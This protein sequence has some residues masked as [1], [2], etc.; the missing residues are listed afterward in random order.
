MSV[1]RP[2]GQ[3]YQYLGWSL[4]AVNKASG[5][6]ERALGTAKGDITSLTPDRILGAAEQADKALAWLAAAERYRERNRGAVPESAHMDALEAARELEIGT[7]V[8]RRVSVLVSDKD[9]AQ[10]PSG[11]AAIV[12]GLESG[13]LQYQ[14]TRWLLDSALHGTPA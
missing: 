5:R 13:K 4:D 8:L 14:S 2:H 1:E 7:Q 6:V 3:Y 12:N 11:R 10:D 9:I